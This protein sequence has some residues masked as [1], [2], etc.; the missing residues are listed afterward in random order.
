MKLVFI[1]FYLVS[2][3][4]LPHETNNL[5]NSHVEVFKYKDFSGEYIKKREIK[6]ENGKLISRIKLFLKD[7]EL[8]SL[9]SVSA[10]GTLKNSQDIYILPKISQFKVWFDKKEYFSQLKLDRK[11]RVLETVVK[12]PEKKWNGEKTFKLPQTPYICFFSQLPECLKMQKL[13]LKAARK[14]LAFYVIWDN[15]PFHVEQF[16]GVDPSPFFLAT[17]KLDGY[18]KKI[19]KYS[20]DIGNQILSF[21]FDNNLNYIKMFWVSQGIIS[22]LSQKE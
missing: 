6:K 13:L 14:N 4:Q 19:V 16:D 15:Y 17:L 11:K 1:L 12:S 5:K 7:Q 22:E 9:V 10:I 18:S 20:L 2:C 21:H 8:E 3:T